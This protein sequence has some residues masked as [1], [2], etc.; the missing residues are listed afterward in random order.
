MTVVELDVDLDEWVG[1]LV[2]PA[3]SAALDRLHPQLRRVAGYHRGWWDA[4]GRPTGGTAG[5]AVRPALALLCATAVG[6]AAEDAVPA[7]V[8]VELVH[9]FSLLHDDVMD[10]DRTRRHQPTAWAAFGIPA[11][12]LAGDALAAL[13]TEVLLAAEEPLATLGVRRLTGAVRR[14]IDGQ[15]ADLAFERRTDVTPAECL[16]MA[17]GKTGALLGCAAELGA[18]AGGADPV[19]ADR[20]RRFG[21]HL[22]LAFQLVDDLLGI[23]GDPR[24]TGKPVMADLRGGKKSLPVV[25]ALAAGNAA[26]AELADRYHREEPPT[27]A[28][29]PALAALVE[30]AG[31]R[32]WAQ[33]RADRELATALVCLQAAA[34]AP[35]AADRLVGLAR[36][37]GR[38]EF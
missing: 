35:A 34:P 5:K 23:W 15:A 32:R 1:D 8:A 21:E 12:V 33:A 28:E 38:R 27:E 37:L 17:A 7:A 9:D 3:L 11:A 26:A 10:G 14:L 13:A 31:G 29:L 25:A 24:A 16:A 36:R 2:T 6:G 22:G 20:L 4:A 19:R 30:R 18:L